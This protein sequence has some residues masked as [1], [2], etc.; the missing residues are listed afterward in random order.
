MRKIN[1]RLAWPVLAVV[2]G[3]AFSGPAARAQSDGVQ[4]LINRID[5]LQRELVTLQR[6]YYQGKP[7]PPAG[8]QAVARQPAARGLDPRLAARLE[9]RLT[10]LETQIR[11]LTGKA[12]ELQ[13]AVG[14]FDSRF[15]K[16]VTD[17]DLR[18]RTLEQ[19]AT[20]GAN[21]DPTAAADAASSVTP[22]PP[23]S[24]ATRAPDRTAPDAPPQTL[25][26]VPG[27]PFD[28]TEAAVQPALPAGT[29]KQQ[30]DHAISLMLNDQNFSGAERAL[31]AFID[32]HPE[33][34]LAGNAHYWLGETFYVRKDFRQAAF[35]FADGYQRFPR[36]N[37]APDNLLKLGMA[38][39][40]LGQ[41][42]EACTAFERL[43]SNFPNLGDTLKSRIQR[44]RQRHRCR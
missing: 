17:V 21:A 6:A 23:A 22:P 31:K 25:G 29:P 15:S 1:I 3:A 9:I 32:E 8:A 42:K 26:T 33:N 37:K 24:V 41:A 13:H 7:V 40:Q 10:E 12:E 35:T 39:G 11:K 20:P 4:E 36:S 38:L 16:L 28:R 44:Q 19:A 2:L 18:L 43:L 34:V 5:R 27:R 30:Y 14:Q